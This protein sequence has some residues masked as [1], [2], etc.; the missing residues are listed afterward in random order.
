[1]AQAR[2]THRLLVFVCEVN[3]MRKA[4]CSQSRKRFDWKVFFHS[5]QFQIT[6]FNNRFNQLFKCNIRRFAPRL[7]YFRLSFPFIHLA[8]V[9]NKN[10]ASGALCNLLIKNHS[11]TSKT[12]VFKRKNRISRPK[13]GCRIALYRRR[14]FLH[15]GLMKFGW[16][17][18]SHLFGWN[19]L[20][21]S[22]GTWRWSFGQRC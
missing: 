10:L 20:I 2:W 6:R 19:L 15:A 5:F 11:E 16:M 22:P 18:F 13:W 7:F 21:Q 9:K 12:S 1:M 17:P 4:V 14:S 3:C 8:N